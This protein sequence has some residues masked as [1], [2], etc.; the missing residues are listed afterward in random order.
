MDSDAVGFVRVVGK[1]V[2]DIA[3]VFPEGVEAI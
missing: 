3:M 2:S 1:W